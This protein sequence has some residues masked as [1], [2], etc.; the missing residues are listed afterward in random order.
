MTTLPLTFDDV[1]PP[2]PILFQLR[3][4]QQRAFDAARR[5]LAGGR[6]S[7]LVVMATGTGKTVVFGVIARYVVAKGNRCLILAHRDLLIKQA[8]AKLGYCGVDSSI[9]MGPAHA[10]ELHD[11]PV[12]VG[13]VQS[14]RGKRLA[15]WPRDYFDLLIVDEAHHAA[16]ASYQTI[17][18]HFDSARR[19]GF[20]ATPA[21]AD[22]IGLGGSFESVAYSYT[23]WDA[24]EDTPPSLAPLES[25]IFQGFDVDL[26][27]VRKL[28]KDLNLADL[29]AAITPLV[30]KMGNAIAQTVGDRKTL[31]F[32]PCVAS[33]QGMATGLQSMGLRAHWIS[34]ALDDAEE[35]RRIQA[36]LASELQYLVNCGI[37]TEGFDCP[38]LEAVVLKP[39]RSEGL[40][41]QM[42]G[43]ATRLAPGK[44]NGLVVDFHYLTENI[45]LV[46]MADLAPGLD[47][48][49]REEAHKIYLSGEK[50]DVRQAIERAARNVE[51]KRQEELV[52]KAQRREV[53]C[54]T[55][56]FQPSQLLEAFGLASYD[57]P[58]AI[59]T[60]MR[61]D[62]L[63]T[64]TELGLEC[65]DDYDAT[66]AERVIRTVEARR[67]MGLASPKQIR[68]LVRRGI[69][70]ER[71]RSMSLREASMVISNLIGS[72]D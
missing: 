41:Q 7:T 26:R 17:F 19:I 16:A 59:R 30:E 31:I 62:Q 22:K 48:K 61:A 2:P 13:S 44:K 32:T 5:E 37:A 18:K 23:M 15:A 69:P 71:A 52:I 57:T 6:K 47:A 64:F 29:S 58:P 21:R 24:W 66:R 9:E 34:G 40:Y 28:G 39:T 43:R 65:P 53:R 4:Y 3:P 72:K 42:I 49:T 35:T 54:K 10:R 33:A 63:K 60:P 12:V 1:S 46:S 45:N 70:M 68:L 36:F 55:K 14:L 67:R 38:D 20:T 8:V 56:T 50:I 25:V 51:K 27:S 11:P